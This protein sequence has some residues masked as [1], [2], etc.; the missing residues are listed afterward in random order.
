MEA[1]NA[2]LKDFVNVCCMENF[3]ETPGFEDYDVNQDP[4][5]FARDYRD[6]LL[7]REDAEA[8]VKQT[9]KD[10][11]KHNPD[12]VTNELA[13]CEVSKAVRGHNKYNV[14]IPRE[15]I[16]SLLSESQT[17]QKRRTAILAELIQTQF[18][19]SGN[20]HLAALQDDRFIVSTDNNAKLIGLLQAR[21]DKIAQ[22]SK[23]K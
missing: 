12:L 16:T 20:I 19:E 6:Y 10:F 21:A 17:N 11:I 14:K 22:T 3:C 5:K 1:L 13:Y 15:N 9:V 4:S 7:G 8:F 18:A 23:S 2:F